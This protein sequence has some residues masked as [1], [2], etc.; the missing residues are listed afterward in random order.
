MMQVDLVLPEEL[1]ELVRDKIT[2]DPSR[3]PVFSKVIM[4]LGQIL[5]G[6][7]FTEYIKIGNL[8]VVALAENM[9]D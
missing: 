4:K 1:L 5:E 2:G 9:Q 6:D 8:L 7:F 3:A